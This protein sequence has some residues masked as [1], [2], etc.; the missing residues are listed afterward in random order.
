V[1]RFLSEKMARLPRACDGSVAVEFGLIS[2]PLFMLIIGLIEVA[3]MYA[4]A[5]VLE[6]ST[7]VTSR[8]I[9]TGQVQQAADPEALFATTLCT[10]VQALMDC[11]RLQYEVI[12]P[13]GNSFNAADDVEPQ[14][15]AGGELIPSGFDAG[16]VSDVVVI[17]TS[18]RYRFLVPFMADILANNADNGVTLLSTVTLRNEP[19]DFED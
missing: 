17:R 9:R 5:I 1:L 7:V 19:Y 16:G 3:L 12:Q 18:Y 14:F 13:A 10:Q 2:I 6:G 15:D 8:L 11:G 4:S